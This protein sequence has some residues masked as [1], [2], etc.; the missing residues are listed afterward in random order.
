MMP[1]GLSDTRQEYE[2]VLGVIETYADGLYDADAEV[3]A[4]VFHPD[5]V[6][7]GTAPGHETVLALSEYL[8]VVDA[9]TPPSA[10]GEIRRDRIFDVSFGGPAMAFVTAGMSMMGRRYTDFLTLIKTDGQ[11]RIVA[12]VFHFT[13]EEGA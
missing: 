9:R 13:P 10:N 7:A 3:L 11:W 6:Y 4:T 5:L 1:G 12:K 8:K 2:A